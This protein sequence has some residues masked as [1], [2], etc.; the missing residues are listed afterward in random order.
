MEV[1]Y[2][3]DNEIFSDYQLETEPK[4]NVSLILLIFWFFLGAI[5]YK[6]YKDP[7]TILLYIIIVEAIIIIIFNRRPNMVLIDIIL[8]II[9]WLTAYIIFR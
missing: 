8:S 9:G 7:Y 5:S 3:R 6:W 1:K 2:D 4:L